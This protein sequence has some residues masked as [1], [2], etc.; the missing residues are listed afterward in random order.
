MSPRKT[1]SHLKSLKIFNY[2]YYS[3]QNTTCATHNFELCSEKIPSLEIIC[4]K[5]I[6]F[7]EIPNQM[8]ALTEQNTEISKISCKEINIWGKYVS[9][10]YMI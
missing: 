9:M 5:I 6:W 7:C 4:S 3:S 2:S 1:C 10:K 8:E